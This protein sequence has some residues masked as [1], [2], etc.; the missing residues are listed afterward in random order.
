M[1]AR[2]ADHRDLLATSEYLAALER[3]EGETRELL[4]DGH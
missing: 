4:G 1:L 2:R 3:A